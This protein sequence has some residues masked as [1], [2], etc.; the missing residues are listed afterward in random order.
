[1]VQQLLPSIVLV[2][3]RRAE[4]KVRIPLIHLTQLL[5]QLVNPSVTE[6]DCTL[7]DYSRANSRA[8]KSELLAN[9]VENCPNISKIK[10]A[11]TDLLSW[12]NSF[13]IPVERLKKSWDNLKSINTAF[14]QYKCTEDNLKFIQENI[15]NIE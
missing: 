8:L 6:L 12:N 14:N 3:N 4:D 10:L 11:R 15:P 7:F 1:L 9:A 13:M 5:G 2:I